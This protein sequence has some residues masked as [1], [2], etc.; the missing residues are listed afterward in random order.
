M[1]Q[2]DPIDARRL[3]V[4]RWRRQC[5][6]DG[7]VQADYWFRMVQDTVEEASRG[8]GALLRHLREGIAAGRWRPG[9]RL[10]TERALAQRFGLARNTLRRRLDDLAAEGAI[11]RIVGSGT[12]VAE[13]AG[14][15]PGGATDF[16]DSS[17]A[18][19]MEF[20]LLLEPQVVELA[21]AR[22]NAADFARMEACLA[23]SEAAGSI[24]EF[25]DWDGALHLAVVAAARNDVA[26]RVYEA[27]NAVRRGGA[28][29]TLKERTL[30]PARRR[31]YEVQHRS[32]VTTL[33][34][35]DAAAARTVLRDHLSAVRDALLGPVA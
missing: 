11:V 10:P 20:R 14:E 26:S 24:A 12:Y 16:A 35:R 28:W 22:A 5:D 19:V 34:D 7:G 30:T 27:V 2:S 33:R 29:G 15:R 13:P 21:A 23:R 18:E 1:N 8:T 9:D 25:E 4:V 3:D 6:V 32:L 31:L 17:P